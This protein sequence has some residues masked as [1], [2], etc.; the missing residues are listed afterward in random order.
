MAVRIHVPNR[1]LRDYIEKELMDIL[2]HNDSTDLNL[3]GAFC[4]EILRRQ[5]RHGT[6]NTCSHASSIDNLP[7]QEFSKDMLKDASKE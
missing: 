4:S 6:L 3:L 1:S 5:I 2:D 7:K